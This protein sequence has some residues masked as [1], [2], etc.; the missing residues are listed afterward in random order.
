M[1]GKEETPPMVGQQPR[2]DS[3]FYYFRLEEL[4]QFS[5]SARSQNAVEWAW[6]MN[7]ASSVLGSVLAMVVGLHFGLNAELVCAAGA[8]LSA[9]PLTLRWRP[10]ATQL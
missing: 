8:Y 5:E 3:L 4:K 10:L 2:T 1:G 9:T 6:E 7:A